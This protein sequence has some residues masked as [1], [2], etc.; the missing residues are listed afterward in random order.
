MFR[1]A[2]SQLTR[3]ASLLHMSSIPPSTK[4]NDVLYLRPFSALSK[5]A[6][7]SYATDLG[8]EW[9]DDPSNSLPKGKRNII[10]NELLPIWRSLGR[11]DSRFQE[12]GLESSEIRSYLDELVSSSGLIE[13]DGTCGLSYRLD[14]VTYPASYLH[15]RAFRVYLEGF[16]PAERK[17]FEGIWD[18]VVSDGGKGKAWKM[19]LGGGWMVKRERGRVWVDRN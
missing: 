7:I 4:I 13:D 5:S 18:R 10:R 8:V 11:I 9:N 19:D 6:I 15:K 2:S 1:F 16:Y 14:K 17:V 12:I 3:G